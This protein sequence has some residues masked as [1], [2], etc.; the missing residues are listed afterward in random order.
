MDLNTAK[1]ALSRTRAQTGING[2]LY[3]TILNAIQNPDSD[4]NL[5]SVAEELMKGFFETLKVNA[6][7][8]SK[9]QL[10]P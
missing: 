10:T 1:L 7:E 4:P 9:N 2:K 8:I 5:K 3:S 6:D